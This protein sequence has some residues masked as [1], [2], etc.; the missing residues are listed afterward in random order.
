MRLQMAARSAQ[1]EEAEQEQTEARSRKH[2]E[3]LAAATGSRRRTRLP[4]EQQVL[5]QAPPGAF[6]YRLVIG[7][8]AL[9]EQPVLVPQDRSWNLIPFEAPND[10]R[11]NSGETYRIIWQRADGSET[12]PT[13]LEPMPALHFFLGQHDAPQTPEEIETRRLTQTLMTVRKQVQDLELQLAAASAALAKEK[14]AR[15]KLKTEA[16]RRLAKAKAQHKQ[17]SVRALVD[18][19]GPAVLSLLAGYGTARWL[20]PAS[21]S[22]EPRDSSAASTTEKIKPHSAEPHSN[23]AAEPSASPSDKPHPAEG[24]NILQVE[25]RVHPLRRSFELL[26]IIQKSELPPPSAEAVVAMTDDQIWLLIGR[27]LR[28][29]SPPHPAPLS[30]SSRAWQSLWNA[31]QTAESLAALCK[32]LLE[33]TARPTS[34]YRGIFTTT[35][36]SLC[37]GII[38][39]ESKV[40]SILD[41]SKPPGLLGK[42]EAIALRK[43]STATTEL[44]LAQRPASRDELGQMLH[45]VTNA[46]R[47]ALLR[48]IASLDKELIAVPQKTVPTNAIVQL[49]SKLHET[50][51]PAGQTTAPTVPQEQPPTRL[52][53]SEGVVLID[54]S[55]TLSVEEAAKFF[56]GRQPEADSS[57]DVQAKTSPGSAREVTPLKAE[58]DF[59]RFPFLSETDGATSPSA[60]DVTGSSDAM[61]DPPRALS[62]S[63]DGQLGLWS[64]GSAPE[65][66]PVQAHSSAAPRLGRKHR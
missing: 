39:L 37:R 42:G 63:R 28:N 55:K 2:A 3:Q 57:S 56:R 51:L 43:L 6:G 30:S 64:E 65:R 29:A 8:D 66:E 4:L 33:S 27:W 35:A 59:A 34:P 17:D 46:V 60:Q 23:R 53:P 44:L 5:S 41:T 50:L 48:S 12:P 13:E 45:D 22:T 21:G 32:T 26:S 20:T 11:L 16:K 9:L 10:L 19:W 7:V 58:A 31:F 49:I 18:R 61:A 24:R 14:R 47:H 52:F 38:E 25:E 40:R 54:F 1:R 62:A 36:A 15:K